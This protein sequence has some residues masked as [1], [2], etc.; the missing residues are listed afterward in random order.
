MDMPRSPRRPTPG[1]R[2]LAD[3]LARGEPFL[4]SGVETLSASVY[5][6]PERY[7]AEQRKIFDKVPHLL[8]PSALLPAVSGSSEISR[9]AGGRLAV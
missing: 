1:Q 6:D 2:A 5:L 8:G 9:S 7:E 3:A 4:G